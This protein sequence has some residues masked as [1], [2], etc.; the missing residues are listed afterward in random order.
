LL[1]KFSSKQKILYTSI[2]KVVKKIKWKK[3]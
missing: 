2:Q 3:N 1:N